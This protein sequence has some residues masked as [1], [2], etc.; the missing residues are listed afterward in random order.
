ST[1]STPG[2]LTV[3]PP[4]PCLTPPATLVSWWR[5]EGNAN[6]AIGG[7]NGSLFNGTAF[8]PGRVGQ[9][10]SFD[11]TS[12]AVVVPASSNLAFQSLTIEGWML[13]L[14]LAT[15]SPIVEYANPTGL[16]T[17]NFWYNMGPNISPNHGG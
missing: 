8:M 15:P 6:D 3:N 1:N 11:G 10:F 17:M 13:P 7:N 4:P 2:T 16:C 14:D 5:A 12:A 9:A